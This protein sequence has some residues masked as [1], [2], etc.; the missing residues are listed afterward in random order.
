MNLLAEY[1]RQGVEQRGFRYV[2]DNRLD[3][4]WPPLADDD[5]TVQMEEIRKFAADYGWSVTFT[6][7]GRIAIF[8]KARPER[9]RRAEGAG[10]EPAA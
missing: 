1:I 6:R 3:P 4:V 8:R 10:E 2:F 7:K 5:R 9:G